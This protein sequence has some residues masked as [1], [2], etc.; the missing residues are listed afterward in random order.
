MAD[1]TEHAALE[2]KVYLAV[3]IDAWLRRVIG[4]SIADHLRTG[5]VVDA[6]DMAC[7]R[8]KP[9]PGQVLHHAD[10]GTQYTSWAF[11]QRLRQAGLL[12]SMG[13]VGDALDN[14]MAESFFGT[15]QLEL[16]DRRNWQ[17]RRELA[18]AIFEYI[19]AFYNPERR[20]T[21]INNLS[22]IDYETYHASLT[23]VA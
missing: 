7:W 21:S 3:V 14:A 19:E 10:H 6:L 8:R 15:L 20:H 4:W 1:I 17:T 5:L 9:D 2:G 18:Q 11:G 12:G 23:E 13:T 16:L 22:P